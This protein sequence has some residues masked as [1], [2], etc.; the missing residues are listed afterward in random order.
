V[1]IEGSGRLADEIAKH[2][3]KKLPVRDA[4]IAEI[5]SDGEI[6]LFPKDGLP[7]ELRKLLLRHIDN[8]LEQAWIR[9]AQYDAKAKAEQE[10]FKKLLFLTL[11]LGVLGT[12]LALTQKQLTGVKDF[13]SYVLGALRYVI[14]AIPIV[15]SVLLTVTNR[16][17]PGKKW[18]LLRGS[19]QAVKKEIFRY[20]TRVGDYSVAKTNS[21][22]PPT[23]RREVLAENIATISRRLMQTEVNTGSLPVY[24]GP[25][26]PADSVQESDDG[27]TF[28]TP[29]RYI[30]VRLTDQLDY[31]NSKTSKLDRQTTSLQWTIFLVGAA[32][33]FLAAVGAELWIALTTALVTAVTAYV[34]HLQIEHTLIK[35]NQAAADLSNVRAWWE[36]LP[37]DEK[38]KQSNKD[39]L[40]EKSEQIL[41]SELTGWVQQMEDSLADLRAP[42][43]DHKKK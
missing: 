13:P 39:M 41:E 30:E 22:Q 43:D 26:P 5:I 32:G 28:L 6:S 2:L 8:Q 17:K 18:I 3:K 31:Y 11:T 16:F 19:T 12:L 36:A 20:R 4:G 35:Y 21:A 15:V 14:V 38:T 33:T 10:S 42:S 23:S 37:T 7:L 27:F 40:V 34:G 24:R 25:L 9:F 1:V 29:E